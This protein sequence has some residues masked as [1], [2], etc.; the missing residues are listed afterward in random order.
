MSNPRRT[1]ASLLL[2][3]LL[4]LLLPTASAAAGAATGPAEPET[5]SL[6]AAL[7]AAWD[8]L[9]S[10]AEVDE[11]PQE[12][13]DAAYRLPGFNEGSHLDPNGVER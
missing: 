12:D 9:T 4:P 7:A 6:A 13:L 10:L 2:A 11:P 3:L 8:W 5:V 1:V